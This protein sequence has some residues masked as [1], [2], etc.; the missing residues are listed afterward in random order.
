[1]LL[2]AATAAIFLTYLIPQWFSFFTSKVFV[3]TNGWDEEHY[4]S[5]QG[6][7]GIKNSVSYFSLHLSWLMHQLGISG[8]VQNLLLD[9]VLPPATAFLAY[10]SFR[11][12][13]VPTAVAAG[14]AA[15]ICFG[16]VLFNA[17]NPLISSLLGET[18]TSTIWFMMGWDVYPSILR[19]PNPEI[20]FFLIAL[21]VY[22]YVRFGKW[23]LLLMP[24][25]LLYYFSAV[26]YTFVLLTSFSYVQLR[27]RSALNDHAA[28]LGATVSTFVVMGVGLIALSFVMGFYQSENPL[29][30][31]PFIFSERRWP[32]FPVGTLM[33]TA[34]FVLGIRVGLLRLQKRWTVPLLVL[35]AASVGAV[36][37]HLFT[38]FMMAQKN[39]YDYGSSVL[40][41][42]ALVLAIHSIRWE[43]LRSVA[44][45]AILIWVATLCYQ[46]Q[47][48]WLGQATKYGAEIAP[49][50]ERLRED[51]LR[52]IIP[53]WSA[54]G[55]VAFSTPKMI[56]PIS[57]VYWYAINQCAGFHDWAA[58]AVEFQKKHMANGRELTESLDVADKIFAAEKARPKPPADFSYCTGLDLRNKA[59]Y[60]IEPK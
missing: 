23:W 15:L 8:A 21:A 27:S 22:G 55:R 18:R 50:I 16:S 2:L 59:F 30:G 12:Y 48:I 57:Y 29:R 35:A 14:Y 28:V 32:Q 52:A 37:L 44:L 42:L 31:D 33:L 10:L 39:Y 13:S 49:G 45:V 25:P 47:K 36:N 6:V 26:S 9:T 54:A 46:S 51:P 41:S 3:F 34:L 60:I 19:T 56:S 4:L 17:N 53:D 43:Y 38:G 24:L 40:F 11:K 20:S 58:N 5:W 7:E 1:V